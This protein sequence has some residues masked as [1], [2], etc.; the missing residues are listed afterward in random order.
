MF[1]NRTAVVS[2]KDWFT[3]WTWLPSLHLALKWQVGL[4]TLSL[5]TAV[6]NRAS[7]HQGTAPKWAGGWW[8]PVEDPGDT[9]EDAGLRTARHVWG[10]RAPRPALC[11]AWAAAVLAGVR[12]GVRSG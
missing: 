1:Q 6:Q 4:W 11:P 5:G 7:N 2:A 8:L 9:K 3:V 10:G 12:E